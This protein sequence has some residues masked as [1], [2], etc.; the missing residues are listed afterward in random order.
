[1]PTVFDHEGIKRLSNSLASPRKSLAM[2]IIIV[3]VI[4][5]VLAIALNYTDSDG[6]VQSNAQIEQSMSRN[7]KRLI[8]ISQSWPEFNGCFPPAALTDSHGLALS[9]WRFYTFEFTQLDF[10]SDVNPAYTM[11]WNHWQNRRFAESIGALPIYSWTRLS[12]KHLLTN[13]VAVVDQGTVFDPVRPQPIDSISSSAIV[14]LEVRRMDIHWM[15]PEDVSLGWISE[16]FQT[17]PPCPN[18]GT[19]DTT[20]RIAFADGEVWRMRKATPY[21][22][23]E[24]FLK[25]ES[26]RNSD[27]NKVLTEFRVK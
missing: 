8:G 13:C 14:L 4:I 12:K 6:A 26:S 22:F 19:D 20:F 27:R 7:V 25:V 3:A 15:Q 9:S 10:N 2:I 21:E 23:L 1:M 16:Q 5:G 18:L 17:I 24:P 11:P